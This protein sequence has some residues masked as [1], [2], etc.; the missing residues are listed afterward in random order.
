MRKM[1]LTIYQPEIYQIKVPGALDA[2]WAEKANGLCITYEE[3][4]DGQ[5]ISIITGRMD[6]A[7]LQG[8]LRRLYVLGIPLISV[9]WVE[10]SEVSTKCAFEHNERIDL[11]TRSEI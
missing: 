1:K 9:I 7:G 3:W 5:S 10:F 11:K 4:I 2:R 8:L 6:Q